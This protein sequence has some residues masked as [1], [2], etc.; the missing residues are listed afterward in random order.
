MNRDETTSVTFA[1]DGVFDPLVQVRA[2]WEGLRE[3]DSI[4]LRS[5]IN[6]RGIE[7]ALSST[8]LIE[9]VA[10]GIARFR[11]AGMVLADAMGMEVRG[12]PMSGIFTPTA[13]PALM[14]K[15]AQVFDGPAILSM[16]LVA[17]AGLG[18]PALTARLIL[19]PLRDDTGKTAL[20]L[21]SI[22]LSGEIGRSPRRFDIVRA[23]VAKLTVPAA[24]KDAQAPR[25]DFAPHIVAKP[26]QRVFA[27]AAEA[28]EGSRFGAD[29]G[30]KGRSHLRVVK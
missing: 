8:F 16:D 7:T 14:E 11:I 29:K 3:G 6:P 5:Q 1:A 10:P 26:E 2:Y 25:N 15:L 9:C 13:R 17:A 27:E 24:P 4:P 28:F 30:N 18:R 21:G 23:T 22:A 20:A 12:L 19:M